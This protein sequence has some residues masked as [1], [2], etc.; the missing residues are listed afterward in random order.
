[1]KVGKK[2]RGQTDQ[3]EGGR[4][5]GERGPHLRKQATRRDTG[6]GKNRHPVP[7][8]GPRCVIEGEGCHVS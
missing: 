8:R 2:G 3:S 6:L 5:K 1:M 7:K 4:G